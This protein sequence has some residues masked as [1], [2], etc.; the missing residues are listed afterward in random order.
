M[1]CEFN[2]VN[3][4]KDDKEEISKYIASYKEDRK[5]ILNGD[6]Y[7]LRSPLDTNEFSMQVVSKDKK[8]SYLVFSEIF[9]RPN[10][11]IKRLKLKGLNSEYKYKIK[12]L[13]IVVTGELLMNF[14]LI[15]NPPYNDFGTT[16][17]HLS[18]LEGEYGYESNKKRI[19]K[20]S[21]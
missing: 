6:L 10:L 11:P 12:E 2:P 4:S 1:G 3:L 9:T 16:V 18:S 5:L 20:S 15:I 21:I 8:E 13:N 19:S 17:L 7:R 14:G